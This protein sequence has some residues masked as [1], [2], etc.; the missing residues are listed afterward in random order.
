MQNK[1]HNNNTSKAKVKSSLKNNIKSHAELKPEQLRWH[2]SEDLFSFETTKELTP[3]DGIIGQE[4]AIEAI[5]LGARLFSHGYNV[6]VSGVS[7]TG[8]LTTVKNILHDV[9]RNTPNLFD[10]CYVHNFNSPDN[11]T[12]LRFVAGRGKEFAKEMDAAISLLRRRIPLLFDE[13]NFSKQRRALIEGFTGSENV[14]LAQFTEKIAK[15]GFVLG[16]IPN[17]SGIPQTEIFFLFKNTPVPI[18]EIDNLAGQ[19]KISA[20]Q[21]E[22]LKSQY[23]EFHEELV[24]L[25]RRGAAMLTE[26]RSKIRE[27]D[28]GAVSIILRPIIDEIQTK[29]SENGVHEFLCQI[30][31]NVLDNLQIFV[32]APEQLDVEQGTE[33]SDQEVKDAFIRYGVN[34]I[35][36]NSQSA[37]APVIVET[38]PSYSNLFGSIENYFDG[39]TPGMQPDYRHIKAGALLR[40]DQGYLVV[41]ALDVMR[42][43]NVWTALKRVLLYGKLEIQSVEM[44][45]LNA[46]VTLKPE[47]IDLSVKV[48]MIGDA[49]VYQ[50][51]YFAE[52]D[53]KK[54]FK[55]NAEFETETIRTPEMIVHYS[56]FIH[57]I[58]ECERLLH[59]D[60][61]GVAAIIEWGV[62]HAEAQ[63]KITLQF[64]DVA[65]VLRESDF[66][67]RSDAAK[68]VSRKHVA[69]SLEARTRRNSMSDNL[70]KEQ[71]IEGAM[72]IATEG[73]RMGQING[74]TVYST[75]LVS[76]GKPARITASVGVGRQGIVNIERE[77]DMSGTIHDKGHFIVTGFMIERF[78]R[79]R[80]LTLSA[81]IAFEQSYGG[82]DGDSASAAEIVALLSEIA[83]V[84]IR[85]W[86][87]ITGSVNQ[88][89][90]IQPVGGLNEKIT[91]FFEICETRGL[92]GRQGIVIPAQNIRDL[93]LPANIIDAVSEHKFH[94]YPI[95]RIEEALE[96][97]TGIPAGR[98]CDNN[99]YELGTLYGLAD[100]RLE[101]LYKAQQYNNANNEII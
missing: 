1:K 21:A 89:G 96:L 35:L 71:I 42:E 72:M 38:T 40:A 64:S 3:L 45:Y 4:R 37:A 8:R 79:R 10:Y 46:A 84:P 18:Q 81:S 101:K 86:L 5:E 30:E 19:K 14:L 88:K 66:Y 34:L 11:P 98:L 16:N 48:I 60:R 50:A 32:T 57:K 24:G 7:G 9:S 54:I 76:F 93:M 20:K 36:D 17:E 51:L 95:L 74:L 77:S 97:M 100:S 61:S 31:N 27:Y 75:G 87:A 43:P 13:E 23:N 26:F 73:E 63:H 25:A 41:N 12:L 49:R 28:R 53:F 29:Y 33:K 91:G 80:P 55:V 68:V 52:E 70:I 6:F 99:T 78:A 83:E 65:D 15:N 62:E 59:A 47:P 94:I 90:D 67:A 69:K 85:Q 22:D 56:Q 39:R 44:M 82:I 2:C 92:T 58:C